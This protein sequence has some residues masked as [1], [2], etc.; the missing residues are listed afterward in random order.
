MI[1]KAVSYTPGREATKTSCIY[2]SFWRT[3][4][5]RTGLVATL[6]ANN[7]Y[8]TNSQITCIG[9]KCCRFKLC[10]NRLFKVY[11]CRKFT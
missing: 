4:V 9:I 8:L 11:R 1:I 3:K 10:Y 7:V 5:S 2:F 6:T